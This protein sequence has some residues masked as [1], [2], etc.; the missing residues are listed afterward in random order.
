VVCSGG[1]DRGEG[2]DDKRKKVRAQ[3]GVQNYANVVL[4]WDFEKNANTGEG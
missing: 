3:K 4:D 1:D 2:P